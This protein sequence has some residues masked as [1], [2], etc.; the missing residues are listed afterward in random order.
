MTEKV[1]G[2]TLLFRRKGWAEM[3][4][5]L[6]KLRRTPY[7][8]ISL[9][10][11]NALLFLLCTFTGDLLYNMGRISPY[12]FLDKG[13]YYQLLTSMFLHADMSHLVNNMLLLAGLGYL[14]EKEI[15]H[16]LF[17]LLYMLTGIGAGAVSLAWKVHNGEWFVYSIG[18]SGAVYGMLGVLLA[19]CLL[20]VRDMENVNWQRMLIM[21]AYSIYCG[22]EGSNIDNA[23]HVGGVICGLVLG[24]MACLVLKLHDERKQR[25]RLRQMGVYGR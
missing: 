10:G 9:V 22:F 14:M 19:M 21:I 2:D 25:S 3:K 15:G 7:V 11:L 17:V 1:N 23:A 20:R 13:K 12:T 4:L 8:A 5:F 16:F 18:A 6:Y 24:A